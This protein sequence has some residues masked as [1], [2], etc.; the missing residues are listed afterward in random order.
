[1][2][3]LEIKDIQKKTSLQSIH[4]FI[5]IHWMF[6]HVSINTTA[7]SVTQYDKND[8]VFLNGPYVKG[9]NALFI[10]CNCSLNFFGSIYNLAKVIKTL[11]FKNC[12]SWYGWRC[13]NMNK[14]TYDTWKQKKG[15]AN[16]S[17]SFNINYT[18]TVIDKGDI[19]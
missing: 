3:F 10:R 11:I 15:H 2:H 8:V 14:M 17:L 4:S 5:F 7:T 19:N 12:S 1:M 6:I 18:S 9:S 13:M 16:Y